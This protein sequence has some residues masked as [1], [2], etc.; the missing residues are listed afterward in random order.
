MRHAIF[1]FATLLLAAWCAFSADT[2]AFPKLKCADRFDFETRAGLKAWPTTQQDDMTLTENGGGTGKALRIAPSKG[3][4][5]AYGSMRLDRPAPGTIALDFDYRFAGD[6]AA[7]IQL[8][9]NLPGKGNG[10]AGKANL[11]IPHSQEW[12]T[13]HRIISV[14][15][16]A[17]VCQYTF[18]VSGLDS[19]ILLDNLTIAY[20]ADIVEIPVGQTVDF[21]ADAAAPCWNPNAALM[22]FFVGTEDASC[23]V[24]LQAAADS[25]GLYLLFRNYIDPQNIRRNIQEHDGNVWDDDA[26]EVILFDEA[27]GI[28]WHFITNA[29][30]AKFEGVLSQKI[31]GDPWQTDVAW[32]GEWQAQGRILEH[33]FETRFFLPWTTLGMEPSRKTTLAFQ[34]C[35]D[36]SNNKEY[37]NGNAYE[38]TRL[39][40]GKFGVLTLDDRKLTLTRSRCMEKLTYVIPRSAPRFKELLEKGVP[41]GY[42][43]AIW[44][45]GINRSDFPQSTME[46]VSDEDFNRWQNELLRAWAATGIGGPSWPWVQNYG[47]TRMTERFERTGLKFPFFIVNSDCGRAARRKGAKFIDKRT[48]FTCDAVDPCYVE[49]ILEHI[50]S[51]RK[52]S[53][54]DFMARS[55]QFIQ[56]QD[57][58]TNSPEQCYNPVYNPENLEAILENSEKVKAEY[59]FGKFGNPFLENVSAQEKPFCRIAFFRWWNHELLE[60]TK[61]FQEA[62][63][64]LLPGVPMLFLNDN[65]TAGQ[66]TLDVAN[67]NGPAEM[68]ACDPYPTSTN[69]SYGMQRALYHVGYSTR[70]LR[71]LVPSAQILVMPQCFI[72][73]GGYGDAAA[74]GEW[75]SQA[76]KNGAVKFMWYCRSA[77][78][79]IFPEY[80]AM[81]E[82]SAMIRSMDRVQLPTETKTLVWYS[83][84][85]QWAT[86]DSAT[87]AA[88]SLYA[89]L[90]ETIGSNFRFI[91]DSTL[92]KGDVNLAGYRL[93]YIPRLGYT[94]PENAEK[95][96][97]WVAQ[98]GTLVAFDPRFL[99]WNIDGTLNGNRALMT[100]Q[101]A[102]LPVKTEA[103]TS[104]RWNGSMLPLAKIANAP[105]LA[106]SRYETYQL[107][108]APTD[109]VI[110]TYEDGS[111]AAI[112][113]NI[114]QGSVLFFGAQPFAGAELVTRFG[115]W[116]NFFREQA[117]AIGEATD[118]PIR[119]FQLP[120]PSKSVNL[121]KMLP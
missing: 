108:P 111:P 89:M 37:S 60:N 120:T 87:H 52:R 28:G 16:G 67:L 61:R 14:P 24:Y 4:V 32:D 98:G 9:F 6:A 103:N 21:H 59:G 50:R 45:Q 31:P 19:A 101:A 3:S 70:V 95:L 41:G 81:L 40:V 11:K 63:K 27:H 12:R 20:S 90:A 86:S 22:G 33:G 102:D 113:R 15:E 46:K 17:D 55:V 80:A 13:F 76:L 62:A 5:T 88:Y 54:F 34:V 1:V 51:Q 48:D 43:F 97:Q 18:N 118:L 64:E 78:H 82:L 7:D 2:D 8:N 26:N 30:G 25:Q 75:C 69:A 100:G 115:T 58:P 92:A 10:S 94:T 93:L 109:Q 56:G 36:F 114:G 107:Q 99:R 29:L 106:G 47:L 119:D 91:S 73:H 57:E 96:V 38:G 85:D 66:S 117:D 110:M 71:D 49:A 77:V 105:A 23:P 79:E 121:Q 53:Y 112:R 42:E 84:F 116:E 68:A 35:G 65:N 39:D 104:L 83:N 74:M 72:Y 44:S